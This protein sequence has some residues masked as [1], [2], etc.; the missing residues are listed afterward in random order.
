MSRSRKEVISDLKRLS[1][2]VT[3]E[4]DPEVFAR[5]VQQESDRGAIM[6]CA[7]MIDD[8]L[9]DRLSVAFSA[10]NK[11]DRDRLFDLQGP[12]GTFSSR[13][14]LASSLGVITRE[15]RASIDLIRHMR[16]ACAHAQNN[17]NFDSPTIRDAAL[18]IIGDVSPEPFASWPRDKVRDVFAILCGAIGM[19]IRGVKLP[20]ETHKLVLS[21]MTEIA[22]GAAKSWLRAI[23]E[24]TQPG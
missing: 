21:F 8:S 19:N 17:L 2:V 10:A 3:H 5:I 6:L 23:P 13:I 22:R 15:E 7:T 18:L 20:P 24:A 14:L 12:A 11:A 4:V 9:R 1:D 16:N